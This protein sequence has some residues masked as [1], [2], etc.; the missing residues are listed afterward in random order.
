MLALASGGPIAQDAWRT[1]P[2]VPRSVAGLGDLD[3]DGK[4]ELLLGHACRDDVPGSRSAAAVLSMADARARFW[5]EGDATC[6]TFGTAVAAWR[7]LDGDGVI[8]FAIGA[9]ELRA[10][11]LGD[12]SR[13]RRAP[14]MVFVY[15][16]RTGAHVSTLQGLTPGD[17]FGFELLGR[18]LDGDGR[19]ELVVGAPG[20]GTVCAFADATGTCRWHVTE[21]HAATNFGAALD[22]VSDFDQDGMVELVVGAP[23]RT[24]GTAWIVSLARG[25][26]RNHVATDAGA[27]VSWYGSA[28]AGLGDVDGE[29]GAEYAIGAAVRDA[30]EVGWTSAYDGALGLRLARL[31][32]G[33]RKAD[34]TLSMTA[35][36]DLDGDRVPDLVV[37]KFEIRPEAFSHVGW[38]GFGFLEARSGRTGELLWSTPADEDGPLVGGA[39]ASAGDVDGDGAADLVVHAEYGCAGTAYYRVLSGRTGSLVIDRLLRAPKPDSTKQPR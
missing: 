27:P 10:R 12:P 36:G 6:P 13:P 17:G 14:G 22:A 2:A 8:E 24:G 21:T 28:V 38:E 19:A 7:D 33:S 29:P 26:V 25:G 35:P 11:D 37:S 30:H 34:A 9:P 23:A 5:Y 39:V 16:G 31:R 32:A 3:G 4:V 18:D 15:S 1:Y 20:S